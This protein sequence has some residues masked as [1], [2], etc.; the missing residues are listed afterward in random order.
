MKGCRP[1]TDD[2]D[3]A[4]FSAY[5]STRDR[6]M[7]ALCSRTGLRITE[8]C[9][10]RVCDVVKNG[11]VVKTLHI[12]RR[13]TKG[14]KHGAHLKLPQDV[15]LAI[16]A[17]VKW[18][19]DNGYAWPDCYLLKSPRGT[20]MALTRSGAYRGMLSAAGRAGVPASRLGTHSFRKT[21][22]RRM[23]EWGLNELRSGAALNPYELLRELLRHDSIDSTFSYVVGNS[24]LAERA[25]MAQPRLVSP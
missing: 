25:L 5:A 10:I 2:E 22:A 8:A 13:H 21:Y 9:S 6:C 24:A 17:Q 11:E 1:L 16:F 14:K 20:N 18:L 19:R 12:R 4:I 23:E 15:R 3:Q 7:H